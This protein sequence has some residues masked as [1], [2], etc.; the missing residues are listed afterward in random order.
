MSAYRSAR[1]D[2]LEAALAILALITLF[3]LFSAQRLP[4]EQPRGP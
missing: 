4:T 2:G 3:A 1:I